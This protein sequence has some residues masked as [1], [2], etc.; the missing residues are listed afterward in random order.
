MNSRDT[1]QQE[2]EINTDAE[3]LSAED[4]LAIAELMSTYD[5]AIDNGDLN[6]TVN[7]FTTDGE[8]NAA[9]GSGQGTTGLTQF[10]QQLF[11]SGFDDGA[12]HLTGNV[13]LEG[14]SESGTATGFSYL[15]VFQGDEEP[16]VT[17]TATQTDTFRRENG[18]WK[19][20]SRQLDV[21]PGYTN[22]DVNGDDLLTGTP[23]NDVLNG[24][25]GDD[26]LFGLTGDDQIS[27]GSGNDL[28]QGDRG[29]DELFG[30]SGQDILS[31]GLGIDTLTGNE[32]PDIFVVQSQNSND[33][34]SDAKNYDIINDFESGDLLTLDGIQFEQLSIS[35]DGSNTN[36]FDAHNNE[37]LST[38]I[39]TSANEITEDVLIQGVV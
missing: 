20:A 15:I 1:T 22:A 37:L 24:F 18:V 12:R 39:N 3:T 17:A 38:L 4:Q 6:G 19:I 32:G 36:I 10:H 31:G 5:I 26:R 33:V 35:Q 13:T 29:G 8:I 11:D 2:A 27:G 9:T 30:N 28:I 23:D 16:G 14:D 7:S 34:N 25:Q 21:D